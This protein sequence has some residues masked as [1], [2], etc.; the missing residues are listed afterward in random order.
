MVDHIKFAAQFHDVSKLFF[1]INVV[2]ITLSV[3]GLF[4]LCVTCSSLCD[5][6]IFLEFDG[7]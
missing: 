1:S 4:L 2:T 7:N 5:S 3:E 6:N